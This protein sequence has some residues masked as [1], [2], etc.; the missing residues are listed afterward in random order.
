LNSNTLR[1]QF[2]K[3]VLSDRAYRYWVLK[4]LFG[5]QTPAEKVHRVSKAL[6]G[7]GF[8]APDAPVLSPLAEKR[9]EVGTLNRAEEN[10]L[11]WRLPKYWRQFVEETLL[12]PPGRKPPAREEGQCRSHRRE[13]AA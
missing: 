1:K 11:K 2:A 4:R 9:T 13:E 5:S 10:L 6:N 8:S 12:D 3:R 7:V